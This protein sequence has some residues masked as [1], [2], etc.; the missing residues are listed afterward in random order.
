MVSYLKNILLPTKAECG[1]IVYSEAAASGLPC[2]TYLTGGS[3]DYVVDG[4]N[5]RT[6][7]LGSSANEF[8]DQII[9]DIE[10]GNMPK[11][12]EG[13]FHLYR[14][15]LSWDAWSKG[16]SNIMRKIG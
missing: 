11:F 16:F 2:Y 13:A 5:G 12:R 3:G 14:E 7:P 10:E 8:A 15:K 9:K 6:L 4:V 1:A